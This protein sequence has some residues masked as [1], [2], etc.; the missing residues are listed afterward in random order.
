VVKAVARAAR[1]HSPVDEPIDVLPLSDVLA[2]S[3]AETME[4]L[5]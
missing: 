3:L 5:W 4:P 1:T 2:N